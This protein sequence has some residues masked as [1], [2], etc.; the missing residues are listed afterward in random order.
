M[1][2]SM[3]NNF[4]HASCACLALLACATWA[5]AQSEYHKFTFNVGGGYTMAV[6]N[7]SN[8]L[9]SGGNVEAGAGINLNP[10]LSMNGT[11]MF[12]GLGVTR[13]ALD[14]ASMPD[15]N[16]RVYTFSL[17]PKV[18]LPFKHGTSFYVTGG[19]GWM[20]RTVEFTQP[21]V[22]TTVI[23]DPWFGYYGPGYV[24]ANQ[25]L[26]SVSQDT[27]MWD[28]GAGFNFGLPKTSMRFFL[29]ARFMDGMTDATH[30]KMVPLSF[31]IRW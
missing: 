4:V 9:D 15:G 27:G 29:E 13:S 5:N 8:Y 12:N 19:G 3:K 7:T 21:T 23:F 10:W 2:L 17:E 11:F 20:R 22:A 25:V 16:S 1:K 28:A 6:D 31:G 18:K 24:A 14:N 30:T 26:G